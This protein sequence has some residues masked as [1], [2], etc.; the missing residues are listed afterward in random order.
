M[1]RISFSRVQRIR[2]GFADQR[3][4][5]VNLLETDKME[6]TVEVDEAMFGGVWRNMHYD[7]KQRY[8]SW[9][10]AKT[11]VAGI[12]NRETGQIT[13]K[14]VPDRT[15]A[16]LQRFIKERVEDGTVVY[17]DD[18]TA[19]KGMP[20]HDSVNH[21]K[22]NFVDGDVHTNGMENLKRGYKGIYHRM[23][24]RHRQRYVNEFA[25]RY[26]IRALDTLEKMAIVSMGLFGKRLRRK[27]LL[28]GRGAVG[29]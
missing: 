9:H 17:T 3:D 12:K 26:N 27:D 14:V 18:H 10:Q 4:E 2:E 13:A 20:N 25:G 5:P 22:W 29:A 23:S 21:N 7:R 11:I 1:S 19:Y 24:S 8:D 28:L 6:G 16:T 15:A